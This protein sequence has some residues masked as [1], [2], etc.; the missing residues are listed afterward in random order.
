MT[1]LPLVGTH[2][3][4]EILALFRNMVI[5]RPFDTDST[6]DL[7]AY[8]EGAGYLDIVAQ[9]NHALAI[10]YVA[11]SLRQRDLYTR[12]FVHCVGLGERLYQST[13]YTVR[14]PLLDDERQR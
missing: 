9:Q 3:G 13:E 10:L 4:G 5:Y 14:R 12:A 6:A 7:L 1:G 8:L 2:L 11:E